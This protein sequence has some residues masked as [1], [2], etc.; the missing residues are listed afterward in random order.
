MPTLDEAKAHLNI[1]FD[2]DDTVIESKLGA[3]T[4]WVTEYIAAEYREN[5]PAPVGEAILQLTAHWY[6]NREGVTV[7]VTGEALP[8]GVKTLLAPYRDWD[9]F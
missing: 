5:P 6:Q 7:G 3:A 4:V 8:M 9:I 2:T 1:T